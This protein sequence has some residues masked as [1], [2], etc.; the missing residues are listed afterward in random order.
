MSASIVHAVN[1][2]K[3]N[4]A[5]CLSQA[6]IEEACHEA[7]YCWR[8]R[9]LGPAQTVWAFA[10]QV[11]HGNVACAHAVR[12][13]QLTC[14]AAAYCDARM[15][16]PL[17]VLKRIV[18]L[19]SQAAGRGAPVALWHGHRTWLVDGSSFSMPDTP[20]LQAHFGQSG[21]QQAGCG[22][23]TAHL[24]AL[25][26]A[27]TGLLLQAQALPLRT[28]EAAH[29]SRALAKLT[30]GDVLVGDRGFASYVHLARLLQAG[31]H[32]VLRIHQRQL[33]SFR[34]DRRLTG[35]QPQG[36]KATHAN[37]RLIAKRGRFDQVV[38]YHKPATCPQWLTPADYAALPE[39]IRVRELRYHTKVRGFR[40]RVVTLV[41]TLLDDKLYPLKDLAELY[42]Q[43]WEVET[44]FAH[45]K[46]TMRM[47]V[48]RCQSVDGVLKELAMYTLVYN[49]TRLVML[50]GAE[51]QD[52]PLQRVSFVDALRWL[53]QAC[54][55]EVE[56]VLR[57]NRLRPHRIEPRAYKRRRK[58]YDLLSKPRRQLIQQLLA[59]PVR[60]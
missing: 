3:R 23:P 43:R 38:E 28:H 34:R 10:L 7:G 12:L 9:T 54:E 4:V 51:S 42:R 37:S 13:A 59:K 60:N 48:L 29:L 15:R 6:A 17:Q 8:Q 5:H 36:T 21:A 33:V 26:D 57:V 19:T 30:P 22:F 31:L 1:C 32:G 25:F 58:Q 16:L 2:I 50:S 11:L 45:L 24:L 46:T 39:T 41:T 14:S 56:L 18:E 49:L 52:V 55:H 44:N 27:A 20:A 40:T 35:R 47:D 53:A